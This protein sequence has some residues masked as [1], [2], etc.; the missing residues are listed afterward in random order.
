[1]YIPLAVWSVVL[2]VTVISVDD[3]LVRCNINIA[4]PWSSAIKADDLLKHN[5][6][7]RIEEHINT[8]VI[9]HPN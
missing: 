6:D 2:I 7:S 4:D 1:M 5:N 8:P 3:G 9:I